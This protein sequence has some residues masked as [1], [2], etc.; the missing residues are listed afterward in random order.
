MWW[1]EAREAFGGVGGWSGLV[2][3]WKYGRAGTCPSKAGPFK[4]GYNI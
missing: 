1:V 2:L 4:Q 3:S